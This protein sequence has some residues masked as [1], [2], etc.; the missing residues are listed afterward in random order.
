MNLAFGAVILVFRRY[1]QAALRERSQALGMENAT[2]EPASASTDALDTHF[3]QRS[4]P[5]SSQFQT[6]RDPAADA[7]RSEPSTMLPL[8]HYKAWADADLLNVVLALPRLATV[9]EGGYITT[10]IRHFH[11]VDCIFRAHLLGIPHAYTSTNPEEP[12]TLPELQQ[13]V[14]A[15]DEW[16]VE[17]TRNLDARDLSQ[18]LRV[19]LTDGQEQVLTRSDILLYVSLHGAGHRGQASLLLRMCKAEPPPDRFINFLRQPS[20]VLER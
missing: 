16:Y 19:K 11:T 2:R 4:Q 12:A 6:H 15:I 3:N 18:A 1:V 8:M 7:A 5:S 9:T 10:I 13:R 17:Y 14:S 20:D